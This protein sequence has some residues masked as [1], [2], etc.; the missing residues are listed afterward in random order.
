MLAML[1]PCSLVRFDHAL[2]HGCEVDVVDGPVPVEEIPPHVV[3]ALPHAPWP[4]G[5]EVGKRVVL[6]QARGLVAF[7]VRLADR[8]FDGSVERLHAEKGV[9]PR[10]AWCGKERG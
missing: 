5:A 4:G 6:A 8:H 10:R 9:G 1:A 2:E 3:F 7:D